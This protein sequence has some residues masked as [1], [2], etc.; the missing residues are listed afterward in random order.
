MNIV[1]YIRRYIAQNIQVSKDFG[2]EIVQEVK[3]RVDQK[4]LG[5][6]NQIKSKYIDF[7]QSILNERVVPVIAKCMRHLIV[8]QGKDTYV[9]DPFARMSFEDQLAAVMNT[10]GTGRV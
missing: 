3:F 10:C 7:G 9:L 2:H 1:A 6:S 4:L 8:L 5:V